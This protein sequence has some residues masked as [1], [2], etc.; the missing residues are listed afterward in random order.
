DT[1]FRFVFQPNS[2]THNLNRV[3]PVHNFTDDISWIH[4]R[5]TFQFG[6]NVRLIANTRID[7]AN[8]F[9]NAITTP[10][11]YLG[12]GDHVSND[13]QAYLDA[14]G[15]PGDVNAGQALNSISEVQNA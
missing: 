14:H 5:H 4:G 7:F 10:S 1:R 11:F 13:F 12:A 9:D 3:T 8:A 2:Q 6:A 15:L